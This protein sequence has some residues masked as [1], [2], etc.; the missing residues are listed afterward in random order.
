MPQRSS[1]LA[2]MRPH[3]PRNDTENAAGR[4]SVGEAAAGSTSSFDTGPRHCCILERFED[5]ELVLAENSICAV[6][7]YCQDLASLHILL[8]VLFAVTFHLSI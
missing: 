1:S 4:S 5:R 3:W 2:E 6:Y 8:E 7:N